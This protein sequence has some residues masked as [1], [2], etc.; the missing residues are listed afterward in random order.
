[1]RWFAYIAA[2]LV[3]V[4]AVAAFPT[5]WGRRCE[6][7]IQSSQVPGALSDFPVLLT[8]DTLPSELFDAD[9]SYPCRS[10]GGDVRF[11]SDESGVSPLAREIVEITIDND[12]ANGTA[13][14]WCEV[15]SVS[16]VADTSIYIWYNAP[17]ET[18]PAADSTYGSEPTWSSYESVYHMEEGSGTVYDSTG[19]DIDLSAG[20]TPVY[21]QTGQAGYGIQFATASSEYLQGSI[22]SITDYPISMTIWA[23]VDS[24]DGSDAFMA[25]GD[26]SKVDYYNT[27]Y[28][29]GSAAGDPLQAY[30]HNH[31]GSAQSVDTTSGYTAATWCAGAAV[32]TSASAR[33]VYIDGGSKGTDSGTVGAISGYDF[34][35]IA[36]IRDSSP[37]GYADATFDEARLALA[38]LTDDWIE[39]DAN[40]T[41][42]PATFVVEGSPETPI[43]DDGLLMTIGRRF[44]HVDL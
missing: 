38:V 5:G 33:A 17:S 34:I 27:F 2:L 19:N 43:T 15:P 16:A 25:V 22:S 1:M 10:D 14:I 23:S 20:G 6:L 40:A 32:F 39:T 42:D 35:S 13:Q 3:A 21:Q 8:E 31:G 7:V 29:Y 41:G 9:G 24:D 37:G 12:P 44:G 30:S 11:S 18:E 28:S 36:A 26:A 4:D